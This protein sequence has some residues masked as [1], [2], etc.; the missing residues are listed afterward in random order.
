MNPSMDAIY[1]LSPH[2]HI[3]EC[4]LA[5]IESQRYKRSYLV[6]T[7][8]LDPQLRRRLDSSPL[9]QRQLAGGLVG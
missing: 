9:A 3:V 4:L 7:G 6:W 2:S 8:V 5:D 1:I